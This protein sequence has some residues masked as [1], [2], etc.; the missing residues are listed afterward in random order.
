[1]KKISC[2][3]V[4]LLILIPAVSF[5]APP[6]YSSP[7]AFDMGHNGYNVMVAQAAIDG[8]REVPAVQPSSGEKFFSFLQDASSF[9]HPILGY[10]TG[11]FMIGVMVTGFVAPEHAT[12]S[13]FAIATTAACSAASVTGLIAYLDVLSFEDG[14][15]QYNIHALLGLASSVGFI[16]SMA[17]AGADVG[18][19]APGIASGALLTVSIATLWF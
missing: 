15:T 13:I 1:M 11:L 10:G 19:A 14:F 2:L 12:H 6:G 8:G 9:S 4:S 5:A 18:H 3:F 16:T 7:S 17:L